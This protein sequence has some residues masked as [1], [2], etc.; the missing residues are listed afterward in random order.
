MAWMGHEDLATT[1]KYLHYATR[2][3][4]AQLIGR[5]FARDLPASIGVSVDFIRR[6]FDPLDEP[7]RLD[8]AQLMLL[9]D[10]LNIPR[11]PGLS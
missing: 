11:V 5:A 7:Y 8:G 1:Q 6:G 3:S 10:S 2:L 4:E 9:D